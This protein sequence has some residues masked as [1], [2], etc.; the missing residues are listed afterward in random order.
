M[1]C[2]SPFEV[3][4]E[5][6]KGYAVRCGRCPACINTRVSHW[7]FRLMEESK[8]SDSAHFVTLTYSPEH[9][10]ISENGF[11]TLDN[12]DLTKFLKRARYHCVSL[13][14]YFAV[15]EYGGKR[16]RPHYH[17]IMFNGNVEGITKAWQLGH[18]HF[19]TV[20]KDSIAYCMKYL[21]K[22]YVG[23]NVNRHERDDRKQEFQRMSKGLGL[24][25]LS[26]ETMRYHLDAP[27]LR[28]YITIEG[29]WKISL[30]RY[31]RKKMY[32]SETLGALKGH[33]EAKAE[34]IRLEK[35][36]EAQRRGDVVKYYI[37]IQNAKNS[38]ESL[39]FE[40]A[41]QRKA[42]ADKWL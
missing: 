34:R 13:V 42:N 37:E 8:V 10:P 27:A 17:L 36:E 29:G 22:F 30:P 12:E 31:Y 11:M 24:C 21:D 1:Q 2:F 39:F 5:N 6:Q 19:G 33:Y 26:A 25:Y 38:Y 3:K 20:T 32:D 9:V 35:L 14:K 41:K 4:D 40:K 7:A 28:D 23:T 15:G 16:Y 18:V